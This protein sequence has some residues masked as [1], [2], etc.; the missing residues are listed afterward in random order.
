MHT[1]WQDAV[2]EHA[3]TVTE[4]EG[5]AA[6]V[7]AR[8]WTVPRAPGKWTPAQEVLHVALAYE[9]GVSAVQ[10]TAAMRLHVPALAA[11][12]ARTFI[13][14][15][16]LRTGRFPRGADAPD[17]VRPDAGAVPE[18]PAAGAARVRRAADAA[19]AALR[20]AADDPAVRVP[21]AYFGP[22]RPL[23][24]VR[25]VTLHTRHHARNLPLP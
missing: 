18:D 19:L 3:R 8:L 5:R 9:Y 25:L 7:P 24:T 21:H 16:I 1:S 10:G 6:A 20:G 12:F 22:M 11:W 4:F 14:P 17:V 23:D 15:R 2:A 13:L